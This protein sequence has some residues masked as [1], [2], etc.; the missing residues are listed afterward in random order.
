[1]TTTQTVPVPAGGHGLTS[2]VLSAALGRRVEV[3]GVTR[4]GEGFGFAGE[5][6]RVALTGEAAVIAKLWA[7]EHRSQAREL[8]F[9]ERLA[10]STPGLEAQLLHGGIDEAAGRAWMVMEEVRDFRQGDDLVAEQLSTVLGIVAAVARMQARWLGRLDGEAWLPAAP[11]FRRDVD[12]LTTRRVDYVARFGPITDPVTLRLFQAIPALVATAD[13]LLAGATPTLLHGDLALDNIL[14][15]PPGNR[16]AIIDWA[17]CEQGPGVFDLAAVLFRM[18]PC[19]AFGTVVE[20]YLAELRGAGVDGLDR[21]T[22]VRRLGGAMIHEFITRT[23]GVARWT[24]D[25]PR[26]LDILDASVRRTPHV[27]AAWRGLDPE[28]F[29]GLPA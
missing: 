2:A 23:C 24:A 8:R 28:L 10:P 3:S 21:R 5:V 13:E 1:M 9:Y 18:A 17:H 4:V 26:G 16:P 14:F 29:A 22:V 27:V 6:Y 25:T 12:Y 11:R 19:D 20:G 15:L 7:F